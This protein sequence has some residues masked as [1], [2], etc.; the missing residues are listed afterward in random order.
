M[1]GKRRPFEAARRC[2]TLTS[3]FRPTPVKAATASSCQDR[4]SARNGDFSTTTP[5]WVQIDRPW[6]IAPTSE[7]RVLFSQYGLYDRLL[8][9]DNV[10]GESGKGVMLWGN[11][12]DTIVD[13]N[14]MTRN[15]GAAVYAATQYDSRCM[16]PGYFSQLLHNTC[17]AGRYRDLRTDAWIF[18]WLGAMTIDYVPGWAGHNIV[19]VTVRGNLCED[20]CRYV[21]TAKYSLPNQPPHIIGAILEDNVAAH[22]RIAVQVEPGV[23]AV[24]RNNRYEDVDTKHAGEGLKDCVVLP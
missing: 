18:G 9:V 3:K 20:D 19:G 1:Y 16:N 24:I 6:T 4:G 8:I 12:Y 17:S 5:H 11:T 10:I 22:C 21:F 7:S 13:G 15:Q 23:R 14:Q 2:G